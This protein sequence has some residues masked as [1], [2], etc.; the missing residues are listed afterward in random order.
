MIFFI[1]GALPNAI[2]W[3]QESTTTVIQVD[4]LSCPFCTYGLEKQLKKVVG[5]GSVSIDM[6]EGKATITMQQS[7]DDSVLRQ[8]VEKAGFTAR[9]ISHR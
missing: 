5:V 6:K 7:V 8:A 3:A 9:N 1:I 4:G 2:A